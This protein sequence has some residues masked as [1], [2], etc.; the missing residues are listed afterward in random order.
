MLRALDY[1]GLPIGLL[2]AFAVGMCPGRALRADEPVNPLRQAAPQILS[3]GE[4]AKAF[5]PPDGPI[6]DDHRQRPLAHS[7]VAAE[8]AT[9]DPPSVVPP[10]LGQPELLPAPSDLKT[11]PADA[12][13]YDWSE[14]FADQHL[15]HPWFDKPWFAHSDPNDP[16]RHIGLGQ[17]LI[18]TSW[19]NRPWFFGTFVGGVL[20]DDLISNRVYQNDTPLVGLRLGYDFDHFW[21][22]EFRWAFANPELTNGAG[23]PLADPSRD[24]FADVSL[25]YFPFGDARWRPYFSAGLGFQ[26]FRFNDD[27]GQRISESMLS[28]PLGVGVKYFY[29][30]WFSLRFDLYDNLGIGNARVSGMHN[31]SLMAG[32]EFRFGGRRQSYFP[33]HNNTS[34]W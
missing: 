31:F 15:V 19:R 2:L 10:A 11:I 27:L 24:Y 25:A 34:Y 8:A 14:P 17:P 23:V 30:P 26:T 16:H 22:M 12:A 18:G 29:G 3:A 20:M 28:V 33:W 32:A 21:G 4:R 6:W 5:Q 9:A 13:A 1:S 7:L